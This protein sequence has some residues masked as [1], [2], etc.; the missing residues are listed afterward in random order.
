MNSVIKDVEIR[1]NPIDVTELVMIEWAAD[2]I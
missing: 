1:R 2:V